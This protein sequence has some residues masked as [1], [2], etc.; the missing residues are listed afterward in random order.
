MR[1]NDFRP[2]RSRIGVDSVDISFP[3]ARLI[4]IL[5]AR[6]LGIVIGR[7]QFES[8]PQSSVWEER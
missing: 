4:P 7:D 1:V 2:I 8:D 5:T 3:G 6:R